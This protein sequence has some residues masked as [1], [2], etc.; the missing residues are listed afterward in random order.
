[1][2][3]SFQPESDAAA[4]SAPPEPTALPPTEDELAAA[5]VLG[6][7]RL[8]KGARLYASDNQAAIQQ[9]E[10]VKNAVMTYGKVAP[11]QSEAVFYRAIGVC[12]RAAVAGRAFGVFLGAR[13]R[14]HPAT[15]RHR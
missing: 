2:T 11:G 5:V 4:V 13:A 8:T 3:S 14:A 10:M 6:V 7:H 9:L 1:M 12:R 15:L